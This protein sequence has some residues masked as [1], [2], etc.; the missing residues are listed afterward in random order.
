MRTVAAAPTNLEQLK[1]RRFDGED[2]Q[3]LLQPRS[4]VLSDSSL[5][6]VHQDS[7]LEVA[8]ALRNDV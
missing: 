1:Y 6:S 7:V 8:V 5:L 3:I 4:S 2:V